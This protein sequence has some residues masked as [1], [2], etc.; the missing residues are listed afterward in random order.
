MTDLD[1]FQR[2]C[3]GVGNYPVIEAVKR[4]RRIPEEARERLRERWRHEDAEKENP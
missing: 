4:W 2:W 3:E 1:E